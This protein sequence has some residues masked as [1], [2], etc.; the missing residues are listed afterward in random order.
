MATEGFAKDEGRSKLK[1][2]SADVWMARGIGYY[3]VSTIKKQA[4]KASNWKE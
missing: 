4:S 2:Q 3:N 1:L